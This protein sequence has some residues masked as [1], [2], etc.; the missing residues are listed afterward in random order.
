[1]LPELAAAGVRR[2]AVLCPSF[3]ADCLETVEEIGIR[4]RDQWRALGGEELLL[5]PCPNAQPSWV[6]AV[7]Q[8][9]LHA[10]GAAASTRD[11]A[12]NPDRSES[13]TLTPPR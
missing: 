12:A 13:A 1:V 10:T 4:A 5:V 8:L 9:I 3:V 2:L 11:A 6:E 7:S